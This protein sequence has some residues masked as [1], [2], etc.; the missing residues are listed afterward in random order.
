M[1]STY[2][3]CL[4]PA[5]LFTVFTALGALLLPPAARAQEISTDRAAYLPGEPIIV[6]FKDG[7]GNLRDWLGLYTQGAVGVN[8]LVW[9]Y[10]DG[11]QSGKAVLSSGETIFPKGMTNA[12]NYEV[13]MFENDGYGQLADATFTVAA[14]PRLFLSNKEFA[15]GGA[16]T[17]VFTNAPGSAKDYVGLFPAG[18]AHAAPL[19]KLYL[20]GTT[21]GNSVAANGTLNFSALSASGAYE[22]RLFAN[23]TATAPLDQVAFSVGY[24]KPVVSATPGDGSITLKWTG[25]LWPIPV[26]KYVILSRL[27]TTQNWT[28]AGET[29]PKGGE[30]TYIHVSQANGAEICYSVRAVGNAGQAEADSLPVCT[31]AAS[32]VAGQFIAYGVLAGTAG[33]QAWDGALGMEF[34]LVNSIS[35]SRLGV[36]DAKSDG[37]KRPLTARLYNRAS[38]AE[39]AKLEFTTDSPGTLVGGS[40][41]KPLDAPLNL[42]AGFIGVIVAE[43]YGPEEPAAN[44]ALAAA[45]LKGDD[46][47][48]SLLFV[49]KGRFG[50][51]GAYPAAADLGKAIPY[52]AG[53]FEFTVTEVRA[54][55]K[56]VVTAIPDDGSVQLTWPPITN[57]LPAAKYRVLR[58]AT[59]EGSF[60]QIAEITET[61]YLDTGRPNGRQVCYRVRAVTEAGVAGPDSDTVC[62][63]PNLLKAG[64]AYVNSSGLQGN[65]MFGGAIGNDFDAV[66]PLRITK[67]GAFDPGADGLTRTITVRVYDRATE[68]EL[69]KLEFTPEQPGNLMESSRFK[70]LPAPLV[71]PAGFQGAIIASGYGEGEP[72]GNYSDAASTPLK[73]FTGGCLEFVGLSRWGEDPEAFPAIIDGGPANRYAAGTFYFEPYSPPAEIRLAWARVN[74]VIT[75]SWPGQGTLEKADR[76]GGQWT[77]V[78]DA[79]T[80]YAVNPQGLA[81]FFR[82]KQ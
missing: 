12:G 64:V 37:L 39:L 36:F 26:E 81:G 58:G 14:L 2:L 46:G 74:G 9:Q 73:T 52:A 29:T 67:L 50:P 20:D 41:F 27:P 42:A 5:A 13:R 45:A 56:P 68:V 66:R 23:D 79:Q 25:V 33:S 40:R 44:T 65:Q 38:R 77:A 57:P 16:V 54:P 15:P 35:V 69:V 62:R 10:L 72:D 53:N 48:G 78:P 17:V 24:P 51:A 82:L 70:D 75:L 1:K 3:P 6:R 60:T 55:G 80:G 19:A 47:N 32:S 11:S 49:G 28:V 31:A 43:G 4:A 71:L 8:Y 18:G 34:Q 76:L 7:P 30:N 59:L 21:T 61:Q 22:A 63:V